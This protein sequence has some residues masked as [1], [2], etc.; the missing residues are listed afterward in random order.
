MES[1]MDKELWGIKRICLGCGARFYD[2]NKSPII[3][4]SCGE[5]FDPEYLQKRKNRGAVKDSAEE[6]VDVD[7]IDNA[8]EV[9]EDAEEDVSLNDPDN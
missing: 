9:V 7:L 6:I 3:C 2:L 1:N 5:E 8:D 4:P